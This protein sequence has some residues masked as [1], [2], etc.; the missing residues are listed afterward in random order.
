LGYGRQYAWHTATTLAAA[1]VIGGLFYALRIVL[2]QSLPAESYGLFYA[3]F[4]FGIVIQAAVTFGFDPGITPLITRMRERGDYAGIQRLT[5]AALARQLGIAVVVCAICVA[6]A[7]PIA[8]RFFGGGDAAGLVLP[9]VL[10]TLLMVVFKTGHAMLL[11]LHAVQVRNAID[12]VR[13]FAALFAAVV[14]LR[15]GYGVNAAAWAY[16]ASA[17]AS[18]LGQVIAL[19]LSYRVVISSRPRLQLALAGD[20]FQSG[21]YLSVAFVGLLLFS[22]TDTLMLT[23]MQRDF[24]VSVAMYQ[25]AVPTVMIAYGLL[26]AVAVSFMPMVTT[27]DA[28]GQRQLLAHGLDRMYGAAFAVFLPVSFAAAGFGDVL[29][30]MLFRRDTFD[31]PA[32]FGILACGSIFYFL[33]YLNLQVLA[34][35]GLA[36]RAG[37]AI[38]GALAM[39]IVLNAALIPWL[40][41]RGAALAT[42]SSFALGTLFTGAVIARQFEHRFALRGGI[43]SALA[44]GIVAVVAFWVRG[45]DLFYAHPYVV[46]PIVGTVLSVAAIVIL[47]ATGFARLRELAGIVFAARRREPNDGVEEVCAA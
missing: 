13:V 10:Y 23:L 40:G 35:L 19:T 44:A 22:Q 2:Y 11:G 16:V 28:R 27:L 32:A 36:K 41:I 12:V 29:M 9:I 37:G 38:A 25:V 47:E 20:A 4:S 3:V 7:E 31:A 42:V 39:N 14:L 43:A 15:A 18:I 26:G 21:K 45:W 5:L 17:S 6:F 30:A 1:I 33:C 46:A 24:A 8:D 34:G